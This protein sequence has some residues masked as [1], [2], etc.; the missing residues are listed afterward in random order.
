MKTIFITSFHPAISRNILATNVL[1]ILVE[2]N[3]RV[4]IFVKRYKVDYFKKTFNYPNVIIEGTTFSKPSLNKFSLLM[5]R[6]VRLGLD[7][8]TARVEKYMKWKREGKFFYYLFA[9]LWGKLA[10]R[11]SL[12]RKIVRFIDYKISIKN[13]YSDYFKK[14][15]PDL[16][17]IT[18]VQNELDVEVM[19]NAKFLGVKILAQ[20]RSWDNLTSHGFVRI[21]PGTLLVQN[22]TVK[23]QAV[24]FHDVP[25]SMVS[26]VGYAHYDK[27]QDQVFTETDKDNFLKSIGFS[28]DKKTLLCTLVGDRYIPKNNDT[29]LYILELLSTLPYQV[30]VRFH[31]TISYKQLEGVKPFPNMVFDKPGFAFWDDVD[32]DKE[33]RDEDDEKLIS[34][35]RSCDVAILGPTSVC[36]D[37]AFFDKPIVFINFHRNTRKYEDGVVLYDYNHMKYVLNSGGAIVANNKEQ[38]FNAIEHYLKNPSADSEGRKKIKSRLGPA[39]GKSSDR[40]VTEITKL[41]K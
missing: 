9:S 14:Y 28:K 33:L 38:F 8:D 34:E 36:L 4:V 1:N 19:Q 26:V 18:D 15:N 20:V 11:S 41:I 27:Y 24:S 10:M 25:E 23:K 17:Y 7:T 37:A 35:I 12:L 2:K 13:R 16:V 29:D 31:P 40:I 21:I 3:I 22:E 32:S 6:A 39:D 30:I 5:K